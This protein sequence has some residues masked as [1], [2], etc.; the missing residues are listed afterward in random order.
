[1]FSWLF[2][3]AWFNSECHNKT[4]RILTPFG[5][6]QLG[7]PQVQFRIGDKVIK[8]YVHRL[9]CE[10]FLPNPN[11]YPD[12]NHIDGVKSN[13]F[14]GNLEWCSTS[15]NIHE[16]V[17]TGLKKT[18][19]GACTCIRP[20]NAFQLGT[21]NVEEFPSVQEAARELGVDPRRVSTS[22]LGQRKSSVDGWV[23]WYDEDQYE[24]HE[25]LM[26]KIGR[27]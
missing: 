10:A 25:W 19:A 7:Y 5:L 13:N 9:V 26:W 20:V 22:A 8:F 18:F 11:N 14:V 12:V 6:N 21:G 17:Y 24:H 16:A 15:H 4:G 3:F 27:T 23:F 1:M 2:L